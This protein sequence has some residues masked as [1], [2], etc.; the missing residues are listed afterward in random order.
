[1]DIKKITKET[2]VTVRADEKTRDTFSR[3]TSLFQVEPAA[4]VFPES[5]RD[6]EKL[7]AY[8][9]R[10]KEEYP[11]LSLT[12]RSA[13]TDITGGPLNESLIMSCTEGLNEVKELSNNHAV[14]QPGVFY[15]DFEHEITP[16]HV[17][18]PTYP[19]SK[20][21]A[22]LGGMIMNNCGG[23]KTLRYGQMRNFVNS[24]SMVLA[25]GNEST[26]GPVS[27]AELEAK[28]AQD[29]FAGEVYRRMHQLLEENYDL[30]KDAEPNTS[31]N[32]A[33]YALWDVW[34]RDTGIFDMSQLFVGSQG[35]L[36]MMT[37]ANIRLVAEKQ[38]TRLI[39]VFLPGWDDLPKLVNELLVHDPE[40]LEV[41]D[42]DT[43]LLGLRFFPEI[44]KKAGKSLL[45]FALEFLPEAWIGIK[46][47]EIPDLVLLV[48]L[49][50]ETAEALEA[51]TTAV[52]ESL[53]Q[54]DDL[55][56]RILYKEKEAKKYWIMRR[57]SF[58]LLRKQVAGKQ[59]APF[60]EDFCIQPEDI[61]EFLPRA[62]QLLEDN[63]ID[64]NIAGHAGNG[65]FHIIPL[66]DLTQASERAKIPAVAK[67]FYD[68][69]LE[70]DG[71]I[72]AEHNDGI[73][74]TPFLKQMYGPV[75]Y[76][77]FEE[78]KEIFDPAGIFNPGKKVG[79]SMKYLKD[80]ISAKKS[81]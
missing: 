10:H 33:G 35:T 40:S 25:D 75:V 45:G 20:S 78:V 80:H 31:K 53:D 56:Y 18:M 38:H 36:G 44:A 2:G 34:D 70:Y 12:A 55:Y 29:N 21:I 66:M 28:K 71:T 79:G 59:T 64:V 69:V 49:A 23:E 1:M 72:T 3:D 43:E 51:K 26:F 27:G 41:F 61:P 54:F 42:E 67:Q 76:Q 17:T 5:A 32:S 16:R 8:V 52:K 15:H 11:E 77:L 60:V 46:M 74:R 30:I 68:L 6:V 63:G 65:N 48:E 39:P 37:E 9:A 4:V 81:N 22:A 57:E 19:A 47:G 24:V 58:N 73:M 13:G 62:R 14:V 7:V 50:E